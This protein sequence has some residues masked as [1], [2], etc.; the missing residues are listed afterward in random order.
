MN[1]EKFIVIL[2]AMLIPF[3]YL[4]RGLYNINLFLLLTF[5]IIFAIKYKIGLTSI[6]RLLSPLIIVGFYTIILLISY[7]NP[8]CNYSENIKLIIF[9]VI[10]LYI[11]NYIFIISHF[12]QDNFLLFQQ[13]FFYFAIFISSLVIVSFISDIN[14]IYT[15]KYLRIVEFNHADFHSRQNMIAVGIA[16]YLSYY[17]RNN[18]RIN[19]FFLLL[20]YLGV[21]ASHGRT[22]ILVITA[23]T[24]I[25]FLSMMYLKK[26]LD[27]QK[28]SIVILLCLLALSVVLFVSGSN[29][30]TTLDIHTSGRF[31]GWLIY[32]KL[33]LDKNL[34]F[35]YGLQGGEY[36]Y[37]AGL[38]TFKHPH[39]IFIESL[40][41]FGLSGFLL[42]ICILVLYAYT[43]WG[44]NQK[45]YDKPL[46]ITFFISV[47]IMEQG[48][49]SLFGTNH[50]MPLIMMAYLS[51]NSTSVLNIK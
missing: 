47:L 34:I 41:Y 40:F 36:V 21:F 3:N 51:M 26:E 43:L 23:G 15:I 44:K 33:L 5:F 19:L 1:L 24:V 48:I 20:I 8:T 10:L 39:N 27:K 29:N 31:D 37:S 14:I 16:F 17:F 32:L 45:L 7:L 9:L 2:V 12:S 35:G 25:Y 49:G 42:L 28:I 11:V 6:K 18:T 38:L 4:G 13:L 30:L 22:A 50:I 46:M